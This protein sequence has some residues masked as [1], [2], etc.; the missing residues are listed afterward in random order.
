[1]AGWKWRYTSLARNSQKTETIVPDWMPLAIASLSLA[2]WVYLLAGRGGFWLTSRYDDL[3]PQPAAKA[4]PDIVAVVPAR[5]EADSIKAC[6]GSILT[7]PYPGKFSVVLIDDQSRDGTAALAGQVAA[8]V[9]A[10]ERLTVIEGRTLPAGWTG[11]LWAVKQGLDIVASRAS[12]PTYVLLTDAD[13]VY[14]GDVVM[15]LVA[16]AEAEQLTM[17][18]VMADL[19][20]ESFAERSL[21]PAFI[22]FFQMLYP[23]SWVRQPASRTGGAA[24]GCL[25]ARWSA[26]RDAG[27]IE[28]IRGSLIDDC[29]LGAKLKEQGPVWLGFSPHVKSIRASDRFG[30]VGRMISRSA[31]AQLHYSP[32][33]LVLTLIGLGIIYLAPVPLALLG[34]GWTAAFGALSW[35]AMALAFQPTLRYY[36]RSPLWGLALPAIALA[37]MAFTLNSAY[38]HWRG[39]GGFWKGRA[40]A[41]VPQSRNTA[42]SQ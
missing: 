23:F 21:I 8:E 25:L 26:L 11:K 24:G 27:G 29:A 18:S 39:R 7:Q 5:D 1:L 37:Y 15:R 14:S 19:R 32:I 42:N 2:I 38:Q 35:L 31:Y 6:I 20:C 40:Q 17:A 10:S 3:A 9:G 41:H 28:A 22:F 12:L 13:I 4:W 33:L 36:Q 16:R 34:H 30:E